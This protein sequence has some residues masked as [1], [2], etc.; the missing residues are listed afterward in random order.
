MERSCSIIAW[1]TSWRTKLWCIIIGILLKPRRI[2]ISGLLVISNRIRIFLRHCASIKSWRIPWMSLSPSHSSKASM[3][4]T[5]GCWTELASSLDR[6]L[7]ISCFHWSRRTWL[8]MLR[9][10]DIASQIWSLRTGWFPASCTAMLVR[11]LPAWPTSSLPLEKKKLAPRRSLSW[12]SRATVRAIVDFPVPA[13]P[14]SQKMY[15]SSSLSAH[16]LICWRTSTRVSGRQRGSFSLSEALKGAWGAEGS[17][18][19]RSSR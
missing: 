10:F 15:V 18:L 1:Y 2:G 6:G 4:R 17:S 12:Y 3:T 19:S 7:R 11:N 9:F 8:A 16:V 14:L 5:S 13:Q